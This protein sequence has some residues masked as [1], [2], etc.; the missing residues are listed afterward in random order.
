MII[1]LSVSRVFSFP[2]HLHVHHWWIYPLCNAPRRRWYS[3]R[4]PALP[5]G[6][7]ILPVFRQRRFDD[8]V[9]Y[10]EVRLVREHRDHF[11]Q[12]FDVLSNMYFRWN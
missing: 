6:P 8:L 5:C 3:N 12:G 4:T 9:S 10:G 1:A 2:N 11:S 7:L